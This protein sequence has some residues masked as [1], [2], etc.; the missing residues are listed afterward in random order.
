MAGTGEQW[1]IDAKT[2][3]PARRNG[4]KCLQGDKGYYLWVKEGETLRSLDV[5]YPSIWDRAQSLSNK[6]GKIS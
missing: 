6:E 4:Y 5:P 1:V 3:S 2:G